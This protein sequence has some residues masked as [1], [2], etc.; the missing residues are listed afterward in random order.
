[1]KIDQTPSSRGFTLV[2]LMVVMVI[3]VT[4][5]ALTASVVFRFRKH[6]EKILATNNIKQIQSANAMYAGEHN[7]L[8][9]PPTATL[10]GIGYLWYENPEFISQIKGETATYI[11]GGDPDVSLQISYMD[12]I[13]VKTRLPGYKT[14]GGSYGYTT[15]SDSA[16]ARQSQII[17][18]SRTAAFITASAPFADFGS[19]GNIAYRHSNK[20]IV[21]FF[22]AHVEYL[23]ESGV[24]EKLSTDAFWPP[25]KLLTP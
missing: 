22:D 24:D 12:P 5:V 19:K 2:E 9:V 23:Y 4:L 17:D 25:V 1:M 7:G 8:F 21:V 14:L 3:V 18:S 10:D 16:A 6:A 13:A 11:S 20:A 15:P